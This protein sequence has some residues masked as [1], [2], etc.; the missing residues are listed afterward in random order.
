V[1]IAKPRPANETFRIVRNVASGRTVVET[2]GEADENH[3]ELRTEDNRICRS[4]NAGSMIVGREHKI[5]SPDL[6]CVCLEVKLPRLEVVNPGARRGVEVLRG[7]GGNVAAE[8][9]IHV[10]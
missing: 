6:L 5:S 3:R 2:L 7:T 8:K 1:Y 10:A 4:D 9:K